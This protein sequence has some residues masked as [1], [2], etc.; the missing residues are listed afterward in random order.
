[1]TDI[2]KYTKINTIYKR[3]PENNNKTLLEGQYSIPAFEYLADSEWVFTEKIDGTNTRIIWDGKTMTFGGRTDNAQIPV[4]L[5]TKLQELFSP[6]TFDFIDGEAKAILFGEGYGA[7]IQK[8]GGNYIPDGVDFIL[9]DVWIEG[10]YLEQSKVREIA[11]M[12]ELTLVPVI[13][14]GT[15]ASAVGMVRDGFPSAIAQISRAAEGIV[16]R[17]RIELL[18]RLGNRIISKVKSKDFRS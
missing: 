16:M 15:L 4:P 7:K 9:Y 1:M 6:S 10:V 5:I 2:V 13:G 12:L 8:G 14:V 11:Q 17:P 3:D 18:D